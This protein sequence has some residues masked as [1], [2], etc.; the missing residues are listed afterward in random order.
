MHVGCVK[1]FNEQIGI[2]WIEA[3]GMNDVYV[4]FTEILNDGFR[5][6]EVGQTVTFEL[7]HKYGGNYAVR[8]K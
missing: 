8:V 5:T 1:S 7:E 4:H 6:L 3:E 2:G